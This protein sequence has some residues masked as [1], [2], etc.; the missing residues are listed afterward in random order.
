M[1]FKRYR[2]KLPCRG[3]CLHEPFSNPISFRADTNRGGGKLTI[4][5]A[6]SPTG[7]V[8]GKENTQKSHVPFPQL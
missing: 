1:I 3:S 4:S 8:A 2:F 5:D 6:T 7:D